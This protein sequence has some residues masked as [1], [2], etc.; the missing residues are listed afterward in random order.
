MDMNARRGF[1]VS[2][3]WSWDSNDSIFDSESHSISFAASYCFLASLCNFGCW[4]YLP[5]QRQTNWYVAI[6]Q[7]VLFNNSFYPLTIQFSDRVTWICCVAHLFP[8]S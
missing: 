6:P 4:C 1:T 5:S 3:Y 8:Q 2:R 7:L